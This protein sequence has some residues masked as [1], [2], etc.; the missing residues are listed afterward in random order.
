MPG[1]NEQSDACTSLRDG[2]IHLPRL[3]VSTASLNISMKQMVGYRVQDGLGGLR[4]RCIVKENGPFLQSGKRGAN[5]A[6][7][8][9]CHGL[10]DIP[11][12]VRNWQKQDRQELTE[13]GSQQHYPQ[14]D[15]HVC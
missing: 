10:N 7:R 11:V 8:E 14:P 6:H 2:F 15:G 9:L 12:T 1:I 13:N 5:L 3:L 4:A